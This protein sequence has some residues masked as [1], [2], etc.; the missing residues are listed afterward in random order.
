MDTNSKLRSDVC[1]RCPGRHRSHV[2]ACTPLQPAARERIVHHVQFSATFAVAVVAVVAGFGCAA[3]VSGT[4]MDESNDAGDEQGTLADSST[5]PLYDS[6]AA[7]SGTSPF[8][9][10]PGDDGAN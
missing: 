1:E 9:D 4:V 2:G 5:V 7:D 8:E 6:A 10:A 3:G